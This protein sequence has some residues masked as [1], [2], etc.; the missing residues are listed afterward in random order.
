MET[1]R[2]NG[3]QTDTNG[4]R[5][6][7]METDRDQWRQTETKGDRQRPSERAIVAT[8]IATEELG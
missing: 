6:R 7:Q 1:D 4:D 5:Q 3:R 8:A 2:D